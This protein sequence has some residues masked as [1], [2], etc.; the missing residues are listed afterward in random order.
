MNGFQLEMLMYQQQE[1]I[2]REART[3]WMWST[4]KSKETTSANKP[5]VATVPVRPTLACC[6]D[7]C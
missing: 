1:G 5:T 2:R 6:A 7:C 3:A 4:L